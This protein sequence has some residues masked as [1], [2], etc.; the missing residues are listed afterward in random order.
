MRL[1]L[2][3]VK[4]MFTYLYYWAFNQNVIQ[5]PALAFLNIRGCGWQATL[6]RKLRPVAVLEPQAI[7]FP[8]IISR[9]SSGGCETKRLMMGLGI[10]PDLPTVT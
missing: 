7:S 8:T 4:I 1:C 9:I 5:R 3:Y 6:I 2:A 10:H